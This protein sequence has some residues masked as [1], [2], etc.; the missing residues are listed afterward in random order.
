MGFNPLKEETGKLFLKV[1]QNTIFK[2]RPLDSSKLFP[3]EIYEIAA[4][5]TLEIESFIDGDKNDFKG[6]IKFELKNPKDY[7]YSVKTWYVCASH[8]QISTDGD[9]ILNVIQSTNFK[10]LPLRAAKLSEEDKYGVVAGTEFRISSFQ[11]ES[12]H[13][14]INLKEPINGCNQWFVLMKD[15][16]LA[17]TPSRVDLQEI[18][19][20]IINVIVG[21]PPTKLERMTDVLKKFF[22]QRI[23][24]RN[25]N[26]TVIVRGAEI[27]AEIKAKQDVT[28]P[29][30]LTRYPN[31]DCPDKAII[32]Q[33]FS[34]TVELLIEQPEDQPTLQPVHVQDTG[35]SELPEVE[36]VLSARGFD[37]EGSNV[38]VMEVERDDDSQVR[39]NLIARQIG[40]Q[41]IKVDFW[42]QGRRIGTARRNVLV[43]EQPVDA[44]VPQ[45]NEPLLLE[46][47][48]ALTVPPQDLDLLIDLDSD[49]RTLLFR[50]HSS[51]VDVDYNHRKAGQVTLQGSPLE[52]MQMVY[53]EMTSMAKKV[54]ATQEGRELAERRLTAI[55]NSLWDELI[56]E[57]L[58]QEY[59]RFK[60]R[61][62]SL[63]ITSEEPWIPWEMIKPYRY[64]DDGD[65]EQEPFWC[66]QFAISRWL[67]MG[68]TADEMIMGKARPIALTP[69]D[70]P[71]VKEELLFIEQLS[72]LRSGITPLTA[73]GTRLQVLDCF[74]NEEF[75]ILHFACH[76]T[77]DATSPNNSAI[78]LAD[79]ELRP[80]DIRVQFKGRRPRPLIFINACHGAR[81]DFSLT[82]LGG[83]ATMLVSARVG[84][85]IGAMWEVSDGLALQFAKTFY[86][87]LLKENESIAESFRLAREEIRKAAPYNSTWL[88][89]SLYADPEGR[90]KVLPSQTG[91]LLS[92]L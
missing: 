36:V 57:P 74:T 82:G 15:V 84:A 8:I 59:W 17:K 43:T 40:E 46:L 92:E 62:K 65:V 70:L 48:T 66:Q 60:S 76:G 35:T 51:K 16:L 24:Q 85:F 56:S 37:L 1:I 63:L 41:K 7:P 33:R 32:N 3:H 73:F 75:S 89:Y 77:F 27:E 9:L 6:Y 55:G 78:K 13:Y 88:A 10:L 31:L 12:E 58:K 72:T 91:V 87:K 80:S 54:P 49:G 14:K 52:K 18:N 90:V 86:T 23:D 67:S 61:V 11:K 21:T 47:K 83:W 4:E 19:N 2:T 42:K 20:M 50:L 5:K 71:S 30:Q 69:T 25:I 28:T 39:F 34:L 68:G 64:N 29:Q 79:G 22:E 38:Q 26:D 45:P 44:T 81:E 53:K